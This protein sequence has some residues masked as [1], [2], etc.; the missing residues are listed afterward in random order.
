MDE[1]IWHANVI[2]TWCGF[3]IGFKD[4]YI[5]RIVLKDLVDGAVWVIEITN[6]T[7]AAY[8]GFYTSGQ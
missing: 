8:T 4:F 1:L 2:H 7:S 6:N 5:A 3:H